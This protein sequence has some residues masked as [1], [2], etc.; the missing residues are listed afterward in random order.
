MKVLRSV[1][2]GLLTGAL[3]STGAAAQKWDMPTAYATA[4]YHS[5]NAMR[6]AAAVTEATDGK[7]EIVVHPGGSLLRGD[8]IMRAVRTG[9]VAIGE[10]L[11][12]AL[13]P[14]DPIFELDTLPYLATS[15]EDAL[16]LYQASRPRLEEVLA[17]Q[18]VKLLYT[19]PW[20]PQGLYSRKPVARMSDMG[21]VKLRVY[22]TSTTRLAELMGAA[23]TRVEGAA[24][25]EAIATGAADAIVSAAST[26]YDRQL[27]RHVNYWYDIQAWLPKNMVV[28]NLEAFNQLDDYSKGALIGAA[29]MAEKAGWRRAEILS[30]WYSGQL[31]ANG[32]QVLDPSPDLDAGFRKIGEAM[33]GE[34]L[35]RAGPAGKA[36]IDAYKRM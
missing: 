13:S 24:L 16:K 8:E 2:F 15:F 27:W 29:R 36:V 19:V 34:W 5:A 30:E 26:G 23:A 4:N 32:M 17:E 22:N 12:S 10:R 25:G 21:G 1:G 9:R 7:L 18:G 6:F 31:R 14:Q 3:V 11:I 35:E 28:V 33:L 20:P